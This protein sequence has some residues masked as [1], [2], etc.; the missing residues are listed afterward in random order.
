MDRRNLRDHLQEVE[1]ETA[2]SRPKNFPFLI[3][4]LFLNLNLEQLISIS[5]V[6]L[7]K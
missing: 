5:F 2:L 7:L 3:I 4:N 1:L 6:V